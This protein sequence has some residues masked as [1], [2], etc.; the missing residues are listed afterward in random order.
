IKLANGLVIG[1]IVAVNAV[2]HVLDPETNTILAGAYDKD[3]DVILDSLE[4]LK[5][6]DEQNFLKG[7]NTTIGAVAVNA[8][9]TKAEA[10]K[11]AQVTQ[12]ALAKTIIPAHSTLD[13]DTVFA[14][15]TG[16]HTHSL[17]YIASYAVKVMEKAIINAI[18]SAESIEGVLSYQS[19]A[20]N[21]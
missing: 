17:D 11:L 21:D 18:K 8:S 15:A 6:A 3:S 16:G 4:L 12:N 19:F 5:M 10:T 9:L 7:A 20:N 2:G 14:L 1:A 13:G